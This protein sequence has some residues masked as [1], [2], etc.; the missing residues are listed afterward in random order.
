[1]SGRVSVITATLGQAERREF[2]LLAWESI[3]SQPELQ[4]WLIQVDGPEE[5]KD[6]VQAVL[7][8]D[9]R[10]K[11]ECNMRRT[12]PG[13]SRNLALARAEGDY[14]ISLD[15]DDTLDRQ[16]LAVLVAAFDTFPS[17]HWAAGTLV[18][19]YQDEREEKAVY[20]LM[21]S[22]LHPAGAVFTAWSAPE[23]TMPFWAAATAFRRA[24][25]LS[26]GGWQCL[27]QGE[28][29]GM[30]IAVTGRFPG[31]V[32]RDRIMNYRK[33]SGSFCSSGSFEL[34]ELAT[35]KISLATWLSSRCPLPLL[36]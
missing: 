26:V 6:A 23:K 28:E 3:K 29:L 4:E 35:R 2:L 18:D 32:M 36:S 7:P 16:A 24:S 10:I 14:I 30:L 1:M 19:V 17:A 33:H 13:V 25:L 20:P 22:G 31:V 11:V 12:G 34:H 15:D 27:P 9:S 21:P 8:D 5:D